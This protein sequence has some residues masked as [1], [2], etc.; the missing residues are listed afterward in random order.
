MAADCSAFFVPIYLKLQ[1]FYIALCHQIRS[2]GAGLRISCR[3]LSLIVMVHGYSACR[4]TLP[5]IQA[6]VLGIVGQVASC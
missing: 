1:A 4:S 5:M 3:L 6:L 2:P